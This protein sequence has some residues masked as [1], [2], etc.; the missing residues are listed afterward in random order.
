MAAWRRGLSLSLLVLLHI[1]LRAWL[2]A[3][4]WK[5]LLSVCWP[6]LCRRCGLLRLFSLS[7]H[8]YRSLLSSG[9]AASGH[10]RVPAPPTERQ[11]A[12]C[13]SRVR[14]CLS[15]H[16][17]HSSSTVMLPNYSVASGA[18]SS[19]VS[20]ADGTHCWRRSVCLTSQSP[21]RQSFPRG[22]I[23]GSSGSRKLARATQGLS[24]CRNGQAGR[25]N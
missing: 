1:V 15:L 5:P 19:S 18:S 2:A 22:M 16:L 13:G 24:S 12:K 20:S 10:D 17:R 7:L 8:T 6:V 11:P 9:T 21:Q 4:S 25:N 14:S 23:K 3:H